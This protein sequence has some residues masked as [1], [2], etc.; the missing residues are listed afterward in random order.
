MSLLSRRI[1]WLLA[2]SMGRLL[3]CSLLS[4]KLDY[5]LR[6]LML[7]LL[8]WG[9]TSITLSD[10]VYATPDSIFFTPFVQWGLCAE[11][12]S[13]STFLRIMGRQK[14]SALILAGSRFTA[15][16]M[17]SA[18]LVTKILAKENFMQEVL[19]IARGIVKLPKESL[20]VNKALMMRGMREELLET[21]RVE[22]ESLRRQARSEESGRAIG[23]YVAETER[24]RREKGAKL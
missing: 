20:K 12:C 24:K 17:D 9:T 11:G 13:S 15:Q 3:V 7:T 4:I 5:Q 21:N 10:L 16:D 8:G 6:L 2:L 14:A 1:S 23:G 19:G 22:L 18:G